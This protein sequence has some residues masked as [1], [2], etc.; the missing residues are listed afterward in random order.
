MANV[1]LYKTGKEY[2]MVSRSYGYTEFA[3]PETE[4]EKIKERLRISFSRTRSCIRELI[5]CNQFEHFVTVTFK[6][7][8][9]LPPR[10]KPSL[11]KVSNAL[12]ISQPIKLIGTQNSR[13]R[14]P[15]IICLDRSIASLAVNSG[16]SANM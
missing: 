5:V 10:R 13:Q 1:K 12:R 4:D 9:G 7:E 8:N 2:Q 6:D 14:L 15:D 3:K 11:K 16:F